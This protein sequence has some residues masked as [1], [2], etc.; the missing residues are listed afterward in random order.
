MTVQTAD[1]TP[2]SGLAPLHL[3]PVRDE[4][5]VRETICE[6][7]GDG[8]RR[9]NDDLLLTRQAREIADQAATIRGLESRLARASAN[10]PLP[11][12]PPTSVAADPGSIPIGG[13]PGSTEEAA[14][15]IDVHVQKVTVLPTAFTNIGSLLDVFA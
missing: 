12:V 7:R 13:T 14:S 11:W 2:F 10:A 8:E 3:T 4:V 15:T 6:P 9:R 5:V 1:M